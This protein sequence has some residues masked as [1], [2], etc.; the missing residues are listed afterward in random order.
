[1]G[2]RIGL[3]LGTKSTDYPHMIRMGVQNTLENSGHTL[4]C[5]ADL[6]PY[7]THANT[8]RALQVVFELAR[9]LDLDAVIVPMGTT[10]G[11]LA[12]DQE[13]AHELL[14]MLDPGKT[15]VMER[16]IPGYRSITK[17]SRAG[18]GACIRHLIEASHCTRI[19]F[20]SG[21]AASKGARDRESAYFD[22]MAAHNL[23]IPEGYFVRGDFSGNCYDVVERLVVEHPEIEAIACASDQ[24]A[25][26]LYHVMRERSLEVGRDI[27]VTGFDGHSDAEHLDPP[28]AT[29]NM[30]G[31]DFGCM[32]AREALR[33]CEGL[34]Q[35]ERV[36]TGTFVARESCGTN[37]HDDLSRGVEL[38]TRRPL[39]TNEIVSMLLE[40]SLHMASVTL[41]AS[42]RARLIDLV[43]EMTELFRQHLERPDADVSLFSSFGLA[44]LFSLEYRECFSLEGFHAALIY[45]LKAL[46]IIYPEQG[47]WLAEQ[48]SLLHLHVAR[49]LDANLKNEVSRTHLREWRTLHL[50]ED[51]LRE[52]ARPQEAYR[53]MLADL[54]S[55]GV[56]WAELFLL[57][58]A[59]EETPLAL[60]DTIWHVGSLSQGETRI[61]DTARATPIQ[62]VLHFALDRHANT[63]L[64]SVGGILAG[65]ELMGLVVMDGGLLDDN[66]QM[67]VLINMG[68]ALKHLQTMA[69]VREMN[70]ILSRNNLQL[71]RQSQRDEMTGLLNRRGFHEAAANM[72]RQGIGRRAALLYLDLDGLKYINDTFGHDCG[73]EAIRAAAQLIKASLPA[74]CLVARMGGDEFVALS[75]VRDDKEALALASAVEDG[76][77]RANR[78]RDAQGTPYGIAL[79]TGAASFE[80]EEG[81]ETNFSRALMEADERMYTTKRQHRLS[82]EYR[83]RQERKESAMTNTLAQLQTAM[84]QVAEAVEGRRDAFFGNPYDPETIHRFRTNIRTLR[85]L[86]AFVKPWQ[87]ARQ[88]AKTQAILKEVVGHTSRLRELDVLEKQV[89][90]IPDVSPKLVALCA[91]E[92]ADERAKVLKV[93]SSKRLTKKLKRA[94]SLAKHIVWKKRYAKH[95]LPQAVVRERFDAMIV[96]IRANLDTL[97]LTD[98][99]RTH[100]VRKRAKR[101]RYV[102]EFCED[103][104]GTDA[105]D[106]ATNMT[107]HQD[108]LGDICDERANIRL[109]QEFLRRKKLPKAVVR[110]LNSMRLQSD[111]FLN[112]ALQRASDQNE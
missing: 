39:P 100:D 2:Y 109:A 18:M 48:E 79:S 50:T 65:D 106:V 102:A 64:C 103:M 8:A 28:L 23:P 107:A 62:E 66:G 41:T 67:I 110:D 16:D 76:L 49:L 42:F 37:T 94:L 101:V 22:E 15:L 5:L 54:S 36:Q 92:A 40:S 30:T 85:S 108:S 13:F 80:I 61:E 74:H 56:R 93:L 51:A 69:N 63:Q 59:M 72:M 11:Y 70:D 25:F 26:T 83:G 73:D 112:D 89:R 87:N 60:T 82:S 7:H 12:N 3:I 52:D 111:A 45:L 34:P 55:I 78:H 9:S 29:V 33:L 47:A 43:S 1:M 20:V 27:A 32:A 35:V 81:F 91:K 17:D 4:V 19:A 68:Q 77:E 90:A 71:A 24:I 98:V 95:G 104:L 86:V 97:D 96:S 10:I 84:A 6:I 88:N 46:A 57:D 75:L 31:Y 58:V 21:S 53:L 38:L 44:R 14:G 99:E 105:V